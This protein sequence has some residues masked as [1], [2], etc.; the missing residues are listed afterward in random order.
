MLRLGAQSLGQH[1]RFADW[2]LGSTTMS[3]SACN[4]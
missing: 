4:R 3:A 2:Q 1:R